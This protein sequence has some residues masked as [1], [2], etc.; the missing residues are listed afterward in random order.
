VNENMGLRPEGHAGIFIFSSAIAVINGV[1]GGAAVALALGA[2]ANASLVVAT[3][4]G[5]ITAIASIEGWIRYS[6]VIFNERAAS[7]PSLF[8]SGTAPSRR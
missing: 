1:V 6:D 7:V 2:L 3:L 5:A 8:P 4:A